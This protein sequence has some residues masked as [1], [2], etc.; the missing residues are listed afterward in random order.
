MPKFKKGHNFGFKAGNV[1]H[2]KGTKGK[3]EKNC[4][5]SLHQTF[6]PNVWYAGFGDTVLSRKREN[7]RAARVP[8]SPSA[9]EANWTRGPWATSQ[10]NSINTY[11][12]IITLIKR[13]INT[14]S[15]FLRIEWFFIW[16]NLNPLHLNMFCAKFGWNWHSDS[17]EVF[18][19]FVNVFQFTIFNYLPLK[20]G[21]DLHL[22]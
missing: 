16:T 8:S 5:C 2:N 22:N 3:M 12:F 7:G 1:P 20:N 19:N 21:G 13:G 6:W 4:T 11:D 18:K 9:E 14:L 15:T 10:F 17:G